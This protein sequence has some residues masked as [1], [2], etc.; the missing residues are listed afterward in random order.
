MWEAELCPQVLPATS[1]ELRIGSRE[2]VTFMELLSGAVQVAFIN[3]VAGHHNPTQPTAGT[4]HVDAR[5]T[6]QGMMEGM[7]V[8]LSTG[9]PLQLKNRRKKPVQKRV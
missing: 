2:A 1:S 9:S 7:G 3:L 8:G 6:R 5:I 4:R